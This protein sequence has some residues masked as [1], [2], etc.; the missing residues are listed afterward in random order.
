[1][2]EWPDWEVD[3]VFEKATLDCLPSHEL[4]RT[5]DFIFRSLKEKGIFF[6]ISCCPPEGRINILKKWDVKVY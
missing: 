3:C 2:K 5:V 6:H 1:M 4:K